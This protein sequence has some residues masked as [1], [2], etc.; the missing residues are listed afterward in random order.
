M[1]RHVGNGEIF[2]STINNSAKKL[3]FST[4]FGG[5]FSSLL[6]IKCSKFYLDLFRF[7]IFVVQCL[8]VCFFTVHSL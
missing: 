1:Y 6:G 5:R 4:K 8:G 7:D 3:Y 2:V